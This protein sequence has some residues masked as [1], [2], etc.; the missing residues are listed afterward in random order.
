MSVYVFKVKSDC[1]IV[2][3][4]LNIV[5]PKKPQQNEF[6]ELKQLCESENEATSLKGYKLIGFNFKS[7]TGTIDLVITLW[8]HRMNSNGFFT[9]GGPAVTK[10]DVKIPNEMVKFRNGFSKSIPLI[11][12]FLMNANNELHAIG[13]LY[14]K[15]NSF[16]EIVLSKNQQF[17]PINERVAETLKKYLVDLVIFG[18]KV[19]CDR[20][21]LLE[22]I[23][24][25]F[26]TKKYMLREL[27]N[28]LNGD[29]ISLNRCS[30]ESVGFLPEKFKLGKPTPNSEN[31]CSGPNFI[32]EDHLTELQVNQIENIGDNM[33]DS[34]ASQAECTTS[35]PI[36]AYSQISS[37]SVQQSLDT[38]NVSSTSNMCTNL[39]L[40]PDSSSFAIEHENKRKR[41]I[42]GDIDYSDNLE[43]TTTKYFR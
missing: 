25:D 32:F 5:D 17:I 40:A 42:G 2:I 18:E 24:S 28:N 11:S 3:N 21:E 12:N 14:N 4:E 15:M 8:N 33:Y 43:W 23:H 22:K 13:L 10:A 27:A 19:P 16:K 29:D 37:Q 31:D 7:K 6:I 9:V 1:K 20:C 26:A 41:S 30:I 35:I 38:L 39:M 36:S 34:C